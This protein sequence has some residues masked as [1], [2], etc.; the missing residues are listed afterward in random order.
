MTEASPSICVVGAGAAGLWAARV[1][2]ECGA[3]V[4]LLE[5]TPRTGTKVLASGGTHC[6][7]TTTLGPEAA[8]ALFG[9]RGARF[10]R[11]GLRLLG[12]R[13]VCE[14]FESWGVGTVEAPLEKV[15]PAS[16]RAR[17]VRDALEGAARRAG[18]ELECR[19]AVRA[20][21]RG[22]ETWGL[23]LDDGRRV[24]AQRVILAAGGK[25]YARTGTT[26]DGYTWLAELGLPLV[27]PVPALVPLTSAEA[28]VRALAG[29]DVQ[30]GAVR[31]LDPAGRVLAERRRPLLF[32]HRGLSGPAAMDVSVHVARR[33]AAG[34]AAG[35]LQV[36]LF[37]DV[38]HDELREVLVRASRAPGAP[39]LRDG[40]PGRVP[41]RLFRALA[42]RA[43]LRAED[44]RGTELD[45]AERHRLVQHLK[46]LPVELSGTEGFDRAE[47][48]AGGLDLAAVDAGTMAV[49]A[50]PGLFVCGELLDL[51][52]PIGGLNF[53]AAF[54]TAECAGRAAARP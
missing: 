52:G 7:L 22:R 31:L 44:P 28:W 1:A 37:P 47:V 12:P 51:D 40:L 18:V 17:D 23:V 42:A 53:Q 46:G 50:C 38:T 35:R 32:T 13:A 10:L 24:E 6:N 41:K 26:G 11:H 54:A 19:A 8:G 9:K 30:D 14:A 34:E 39:R 15:F 2:A 21:E 45:R 25:S 29:V 36:D 3:R 49:K 4:R 33:V 20:V 27:E 16:G 48:T 5:K 43:E